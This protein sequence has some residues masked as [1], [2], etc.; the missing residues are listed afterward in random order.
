MHFEHLERRQLLSGS[1]EGHV[2]VDIDGDKAF[3]AGDQPRAD[4]AVYLDANENGQF[5]T[6]E[7]SVFTDAQGHYRFDDV[8]AGERLVALNAPGV[9][10]NS[11]DPNALRLLGTWDGV[12]SS[13]ALH[14]EAEAAHAESD[15]DEGHDHKGG[16]STLYADVWT[17]GDLAVIG[18]FQSDGTVD[19]LDISDPSNPI[20]LSTWTAPAATSRFQDVKFADGIGYFASEGGGGTSIVDLTDPSSPTLLKQILSGDGGF[21]KV[22]NI[23]VADGYMY[24]ADSRSKILRVFDVSDPANAFHVR[25]ITTT[26]ARFIHDITVVNGRL[27]TS[28]FGNATV[29]GTTDIFDVSDIGDA[30]WSEATRLLG[31]VH[32]GRNNHSNWVSDDGNL[33]AIAR[34]LAGGDV[35]LWDISDPSQPQLLSTIS[36]ASLGLPTVSPH[37]PVIR[38][39]FLY[40]SWYQNGLIVM[41][42]TDPTQP[43]L[44]GHY[45]TFDGSNGGFDGNWGIHLTGR[46]QIVVSDMV[47]GLY[48]FELAAPFANIVTLEEDQ[49]A[50]GEN[51]MLA[52]NLPPSVLEVII[53][54]GL[55]QRSMIRHVEIAFSEDVDA[56]LTEASLIIQNMDTLEEFDLGV[57]ELHRYADSNH[58]I[59][60]F[61][62]LP[63]SSLPDGNYRVMLDE[64][65]I[66]DGQGNPLES[67]PPFDLHRYFGDANGDRAINLGDLFTFRSAYGA[68]DTDSNYVPYLDGNKDGAIDIAELFEFRSRYLTSLAMPPAPTSGFSQDSL[69]PLVGG[70]PDAGLLALFERQSSVRTNSMRP[71]IPNFVGDDGK[72]EDENAMQVPDMELKLPKLE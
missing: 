2:F 36:G 18:R 28:G 38:D 20:R 51:F 25:N 65:S 11:P 42:I 67:M 29:G 22:H 16:A 33:L 62:H 61:H 35:T 13:G 34:E 53:A 56:S 30:N 14:S 24:Q 19:I 45:D 66:V 50:T 5:D 46:D 26:D 68:N 60:H 15:S 17:D 44:A 32:S 57:V 12:E 40:I 7:T 72:E 52:D 21:N 27:Y 54:D 71:F 4:V 47:T 37:N 58:A 49:S 10:V 69:Q 1:I 41:D 23:F 59:W 8:P 55:D 64:S 3:G 63:D 6:G 70:I 43:Q 9:A 31:T 48:V 39:N